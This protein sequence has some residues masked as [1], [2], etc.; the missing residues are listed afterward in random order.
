MARFI[1]LISLTQRGEEEV[2]NTVDR[3]NAFRSEAEKVGAEVKHVYWTMGNYDGVLIFEAPDDQTATTL[4]I[5][6]GSKG[7]VRTQ[8]MIAYDSGEMESVL[9]RVS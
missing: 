9:S 3:A 6:L 8:T 5:N 7:N 2:K 4:M 1:S